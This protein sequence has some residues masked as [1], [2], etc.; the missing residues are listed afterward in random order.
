LLGNIGSGLFLELQV[1]TS[2]FQVENFDGGYVSTSAATNGQWYHF[3]FVRQGST[4]RW[5]YNGQQIHSGEFTNIAMSNLVLW[6]T[7]SFDDVRLTAACRYPNGTTFTPPT[8][9]F[10][11]A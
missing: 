11:G 5:Y 3:A 10:P 1:T 6:Q 8:E 9:A 2:G 7:H 4:G